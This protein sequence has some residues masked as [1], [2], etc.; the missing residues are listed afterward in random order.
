VD[1]GAA[2]G[3]AE[4]DKEQEPVDNPA[5]IFRGALIFCFGG[6]LGPGMLAF[7][8][9]NGLPLGPEGGHIKL[10]TGVA[11]RAG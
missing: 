10:I 8:A 2:D 6:F 4:D 1:D 5:D 3:A 11:G 7:E 9:A